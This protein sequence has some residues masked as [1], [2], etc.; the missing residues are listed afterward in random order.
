[1]KTYFF[2]IKEDKDKEPITKIIKPKQR[3]WVKQNQQ[4]NAV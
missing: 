2:Y 4:I 3:R 1:M